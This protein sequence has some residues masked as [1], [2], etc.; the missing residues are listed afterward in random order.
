MRKKILALVPIFALTLAAAAVAEDRAP[1]G[2]SAAAAAEQPSGIGN[3]VLATELRRYAQ[4]NESALAY[5]LAAEL[6]SGVTVNPAATAA[7]AAAGA[8]TPPLSPTSLLVEARRLAAG[9]ADL[10]ALI[11]RAEHAG[12]SRGRSGQSYIASTAVKY[13]T[14]SAAAGETGTFSLSFSPGQRAEI[15]VAGDGSSNLD[16][17][18]FAPDGTLAASDLDSTDNCIARWYPRAGGAHRVEVRN[19]GPKASSYYFYSSGK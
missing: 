5:V 19:V 1:A 8:T 6:V 13:D 17:Y 3:Y 9:D 11:A 14:R 16:L 18:V 10:L 15:A 4:Q 2:D 12:K 7:D